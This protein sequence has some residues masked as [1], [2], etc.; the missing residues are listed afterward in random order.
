MAALQ[1]EQTFFRLQL[2]KTDNTIP[3]SIISP[4]CPCP[5]VP[6]QFAPVTGALTV[7]SGWII[8]PC[9]CVHNHQALSPDGLTLPGYPPLP[10]TTGF[11]LGYAGESADNLLKMP[12]PA[13]KKLPEPPFPVKF[14]Y[15]ANVTIEYTHNE[16]NG[17]IFTKWT[18]GDRIRESRGH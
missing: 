15:R 1:E 17:S 10:Q 3:F 5:V 6:D 18:I 7:D 4:L 12:C 8:H 11:I 13:T 2:L 14:W 9:D 16:E